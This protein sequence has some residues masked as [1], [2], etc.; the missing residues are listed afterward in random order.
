MKI[1]EITSK[2]NERF[3]FALSLLDKK[4]RKQ[5]GMMLVEGKKFVAD[6]V[7]FNVPIQYLFFGDDALEFVEGLQMQNVPAYKLPQN[8]LSKLSRQSTS[9]QVVAVVREPLPKSKLPSTNFLVLDGLQDAGNV[10]TILRTALATGFETVYLLDCVDVF[11]P[12]VVDASMTAIFHLNLV[13]ITREDFVKLAREQNF[14]IVLADFG[15]KNALQY[16]NKYAILGLVIGNEGN[17]VSE[18]VNSV[19]CD[20]LT[21]PM[22]NK[23]ESLN[24]SVSAGI[25][26]Y[27]LN[28]KK[29]E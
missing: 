9:Q 18:Q 5:S 26:M 17:G 7:K 19:A 6:L 1:Q 10:G 28:G 15:G 3:K 2:E 20:I 12:K 8:L 13:K 16:E 22:S 4:G 23:I 11:S 25:L 21:L 14:A 27:L 29:E 24:A